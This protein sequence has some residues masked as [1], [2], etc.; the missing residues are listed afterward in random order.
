MTCSATLGLVCVMPSHFSVPCVRCLK[1]TAPKNLSYGAKRSS[2]CSHQRFQLCDNVSFVSLNIMFLTACKFINFRARVSATL[3]EMHLVSCFI[4][5]G[6][7]GAG[8]SELN[9]ELRGSPAFGR[10][11]L[12]RRVGPCALSTKSRTQHIK[13][14]VND[15][16]PLHQNTE[17]TNFNKTFRLRQTKNLKSEF[18]R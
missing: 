3:D 8:L 18:K 12:E 9:V 14:A 4:T 15:K 16:L 10:V 5:S 13:K 2:R 7:L 6:A 11:P 1:K 17:I